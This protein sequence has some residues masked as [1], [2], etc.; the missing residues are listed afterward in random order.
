MDGYKVNPCLN[1]LDFSSMIQV[2]NMMD[3][4]L[5]RMIYVPVIV[6]VLKYQ[7]IVRR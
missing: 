2:R 6:I 3:K 5:A 1:F 7:H 4:F